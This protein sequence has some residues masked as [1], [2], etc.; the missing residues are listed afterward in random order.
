MA[1]MQGR[2]GPMYAGG[3]HGW[4]QLIADAVKFV[5][6]EEV[7]RQGGRPVGLPAGAGRRPRPVHGRARRRAHPV[8][9]WPGSTSRPARC[10]AL[11]AISVGSLGSLMAGWASANKYSL[12]GGLRAAAQLLSY[13]LPIV[14]A[15]ASVAM[16]AGNAVAARRSSR[17][18]ARG[19]CSG[20][21]P[22]PSS[23]S[24]PV[25]PSSNA[26][27]ST[28]RSPTPSSSWARGPS[29]PGCASRSSCSPS[30]PAS[31]SSALLF[32]ALFLGG[33][34]GPWSDTLGWLWTL[35]KGYAVAFV[36]IWIRVAWP[37][38]REDQLQ[39]L[40]WVYLVPLA[41][42]PAVHHG[43]RGGDDADEPRQARQER[44]DCC[45][46]RSPGW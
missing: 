32:S 13:E 12:L 24:S 31:S 21:C 38:L 15:V 23:S 3:Y 30:T 29:T 40:A 22:V 11:A 25:S 26:R 36:I 4:A 46:A 1:H 8:R 10:S 43:D 19:G 20:S 44:G 37:R 16:A 18:G 41:L 39:R 17:R 45:P 5:Q 27:R 2:L 28:C 7:L 9:A 33:W 42:A 35:L 6:K 34:H 14:L